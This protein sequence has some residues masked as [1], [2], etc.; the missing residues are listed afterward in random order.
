MTGTVAACAGD[1]EVGGRALEADPLPRVGVSEYWADKVRS[2]A[3]DFANWPLY[4][5]TAPGRPDFHPSLDLFSRT[6]GVAVTY[7]EIIED[8]ATFYQRIRPALA[9]GRSVGYDLVIIPNGSV[10][11]EMIRQNHLAPLDHSQLPTFFANADETVVDPP[12][13]PDNQYTIA[14]QSGITGIAYDPKLTGRDV[15]SFDDLFDTAFAGRVGMFGDLRDL[16]NFTL[17]GIG[18]EPEDSTPD[19]W[20]AAADRLRR[21]QESGVVKAYYQ[22]DYLDALTAGETWLSMAWSGD[23]F[24]ANAEGAGL[25]FVVP[26]QGGLLWTD[27]MCIPATASHPVDALLYMDFVYR[28]DVAAMLAESISYI[29]PVP[30]SRERI[31]DDANAHADAERDALLAVANSSIVFPSRVD[32]RR[33]RRYRVLTEGE[34]ATWNKTFQPLFRS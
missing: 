26:K 33:L 25:K 18:V 17:V 31:L 11:S 16:P 10:L 15:T 4:I 1:D 7:Q 32:L 12:Y 24:Q 27:S 20:N 6:T 8:D 22:Q 14:W 19:D 23:V 3:F 2:G 28:L 5:D 34:T 29:T 21:Q 30:F 13:D 9:A